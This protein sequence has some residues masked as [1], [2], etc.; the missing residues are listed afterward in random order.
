MTEHE[1]RREDYDRHCQAFV[2]AGDYTK[3]AF[4]DLGWDCPKS[5]WTEAVWRLYRRNH[6]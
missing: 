3:D 5:A 6:N 2:D 1:Q 4:H